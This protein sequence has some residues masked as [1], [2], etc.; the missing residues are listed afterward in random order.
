[1][2]KIIFVLSYFCLISCDKKLSQDELKMQH[3]YEAISKDIEL[4]GVPEVIINMAVGDTLQYLEKTLS[5]ITGGDAL[6]NVYGDMWNNAGI[7]Y[8]ISGDT[9][10][11][12]KPASNGLMLWFYDPDKDLK[13]I[14]TG[15]IFPANANLKKSIIRIPDPRKFKNLNV[16]TMLLVHETNHILTGAYELNPYLIEMMVLT[17]TISGQKILKKIPER[18][19]NSQMEGIHEW[20]KSQLFTKELHPIEFYS[21]DGSLMLFGAM[22]KKEPLN[23]LDMDNVLKELN[24][25]IKKSGGVEYKYKN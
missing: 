3:S 6:L 14:Q 1:M 10:K 4:L 9:A 2:K 19:Q 11:V 7:M 5:N 17:R 8:Q 18:Y 24:L 20:F 21:L 23:N 25:F 15:E 12:L 22:R 13:R 16:F